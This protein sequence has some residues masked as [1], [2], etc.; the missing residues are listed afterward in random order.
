MNLNEFTRRLIF[1]TALGLASCPGQTNNSNAG[2]PPAPAAE[3]D[4]NVAAYPT[5]V[6]GASGILTMTLQPDT[7][8][9]AALLVQEIPGLATEVSGYFAN[10]NLYTTNAP[11]NPK[12]VDLNQPGAG[13]WIKVL[14]GNL[15]RCP[16]SSPP[17]NPPYS[18]GSYQRVCRYQYKVGKDG[19][20]ISDWLV[21]TQKI[22]VDALGTVTITKFGQHGVRR[23]T[24]GVADQW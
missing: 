20:I 21:A 22:S 11:A 17:I 6:A 14:E 13:P 8:S 3:G 19:P 10:T 1:A 24:N 15:L 4:L 7:V 12:A 23:Q 18:S 5:N 2:A 9:F 16:V